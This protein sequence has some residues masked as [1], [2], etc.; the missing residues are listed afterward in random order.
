MEFQDNREIRETTKKVKGEDHTV[1]HAGWLIDGRGG[2][3]HKDMVLGIKDGYIHDLKPAEQK[4]NDDPNALDLT[5]CTLVPG[6][7]DSHVHLFM[8]D[9]ND[10][11]I[12][13]FQLSAPFADIKGVITDHISQHLAY[14]VIAVRD[15]GDRRAHALRYKKECLYDENFPIILKVAGKAWHKPGRYGRLIGRPPQ[16][17]ETLAEAIAKE[18][19]RIDQ[20]K[21]VNSGVNS[22]TRYGKGTPPQ[23]NSLEMQA[24]VTSAKIRGLKTM[25]HANGQLPVHIAIESGCHSIEHGF[26]MGK[27]NLKR[28][29]DAKTTWVPTAYT[30]K[31]YVESGI[32]SDVAR[33]NLDHQLDQISIARELGVKIALGTDAGSLGVHHGKAVIEEMKLLIASG[34]SLTEAIRCATMNGAQL[35]DL[36]DTGCLEKGMRAT[37]VAVPS[38]PSNLPESLNRI[39]CIF[40][41]GRKYGD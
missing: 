7:I 20:V 22:L 36:K 34:Y 28:M 24:A 29:A 41:N 30:M 15:G 35:L 2:S 8:S 5:F 26:F 14:G 10:R 37:F 9:T 23:F 19:E 32:T 16:G 6:L 21:I 33:K 13:D 40:I 1:V 3:I 25:V 31:A 4:K 39:E 11:K 38:D 18:T 27:E 17:K 12:R